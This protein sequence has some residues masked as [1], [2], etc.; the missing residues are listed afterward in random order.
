MAKHRGF[1]LIELMI[2][3]AIIGIL[4]AL[5]I[6]KFATLIRKS[7]EGSTRGNLWT[8]RSAIGIYYGD[9]GGEYPDAL[10]ALTLNTKY[11]L[12]IPTARIPPFHADSNAAALGQTVTDVG[13][14]LYGN[15]PTALGTYGHV[16]VNCSHTDTRETSW[17]E[18]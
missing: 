17:S 13:G 9:M 5:A 16:F 6:P 1:T 14:W 11:L 18:Y 15:V 2:V 7:N 12:R 4:A 10:A 3:V 8:L